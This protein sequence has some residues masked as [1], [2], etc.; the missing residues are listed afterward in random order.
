MHYSNCDTGKML[1]KL[2]KQNGLSQSQLGEYLG[3]NQDG[4]SKLENGKKAFD[5]DTIFRISEYFQVSA[6]SLLGLGDNDIRKDNN[7]KISIEKYTGLSREAIENL[8]NLLDK[9]AYK[10]SINHFFENPDLLL[11]LANFY[12]S[13]IVDIYYYSDYNIDSTMRSVLVEKKNALCKDNAEREKAITYVSLLEG[14]AISRDEYYNKTT[15]S[16]SSRTKVALALAQ[17]FVDIE[18]TER[19]IENQLLSKKIEYIT[20]KT[21]DINMS[22][23]QYNHAKQLLKEIIEQRT[24]KDRFTIKKKLDRVEKVWQDVFNEYKE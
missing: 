8:H 9:T 17:I 4:I 6:D 22:E 21:I 23:T 13:S 7:F 11:S 10:E 5:S 3:T 18:Q 19:V 24:T 14:L 12:I 15:N 1:K 16:D 20:D 2:R